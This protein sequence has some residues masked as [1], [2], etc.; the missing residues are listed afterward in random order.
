MEKRKRIQELL[1]LYVADNIDKSSFQEL[2]T[3]LDDLE[4]DS[5]RQLINSH[6]Q[7]ADQPE[8]NILVQAHLHRT[9]H[10]LNN[11]IHKDIRE[12]RV[13]SMVRWIWI[14]V[15]AAVALFFMIRTPEGLK[16]SEN[17]DREIATNTPDISPA[18]HRAIIAFD[19]QTIELDDTKQGI[20]IYNDS[21]SASNGEKLALRN[22]KSKQVSITT[23]RGGQYQVVLLDGTKVWMNAA[24]QISYNRDFAVSNRDVQVKGEVYFEVKKNQKL[25]FTVSYSKQKLMVLGTTFNINAYDDEHKTKTTLIEG[26]MKVFTTN[27]PSHL[28]KPNQQ[29]EYKLQSNALKLQEVDPSSE[30]SWKNGIFDFDGLS[31]AEAMRVISRWYD[32]DIRYAGPIPEVTLGGK[33]SRGVKLTTFLHFLEDNFNVHTNLS[34]DRI[35]TISK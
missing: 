14:P 18:Q 29:L 21:I 15:A 32:I 4:D 13:K 22:Q 26:S 27:Q 25:P 8:V 1:S 30:I 33:M 16:K 19:N 23:P 12:S 28:L 9:Q 2:M 3:L 20:D 24:S 7:E 10:A 31:L 17:T 5:F 34:Q 11:S 6:F 35:L